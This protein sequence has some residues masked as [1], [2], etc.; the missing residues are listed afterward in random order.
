MREDLKSTI[1][2][3]M[4]WLK[5]AAIPAGISVVVSHDGAELKSLAQ[6]GVL[7]EGLDL[8]GP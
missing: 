8:S 1:Q 2:Q 5:N 3:Q 7:T 4:A 6:H